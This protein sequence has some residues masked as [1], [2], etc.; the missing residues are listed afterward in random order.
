M[1]YWSSN[2][3][4]RSQSASFCSFWNATNTVPSGRTVGTEN[5]VSS[6]SPAGPL[7][8]AVQSAGLDPEIFGAVDQWAPPSSLYASN[9]ADDAYTPLW[10]S[11]FD[12]VVQ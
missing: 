7:T 4:P 3:S 9:T 8:C 6:Q 11:Y 1:R 5:W 10:L 12:Q 2:C